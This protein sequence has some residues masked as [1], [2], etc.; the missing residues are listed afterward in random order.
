MWTFSQYGFA[1][2]VADRTNRHF[3]IVRFRDP[4]DAAAHARAHKI[5]NSGKRTP[6]VWRDDRADYRW[7]M[8]VRLDQ[9]VMTQAWITAEIDYPNFKS[10]MH[11]RTPRWRNL[12]EVWH[13]TNDHQRRIVQG[14]GF[15]DWSPDDLVV[16]STDDGDDYN[17]ALTDRDAP[18]F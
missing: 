1:S 7:R 11:D 10:M 2:A 4:D 8:R 9:W 5:A 14:E 12:M 6:S 15:R 17:E 3:V 13:A 18:P 16:G